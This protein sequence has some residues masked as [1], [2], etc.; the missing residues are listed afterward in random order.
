MASIGFIGVGNMGGPMARNLLKAGHSVKA[1]DLSA[2]LVQKVVDAGGSK[3]ANAAAAAIDVDAVVTMLPAGK[4]VA[5]VYKGDGGILAAAK[6]GTLFIDSSTIDVKTAREVLAAAEARGMPMV[7]APVSGGVAGAENAAL[8]FMVGG[9]DA[10]FAKA[11]PILEAMGKKIVHAGGPGNGQV[12]KICNN[13][14]LGISMIAVSEAFVMAEKLGLSA[15]AMFDIV[16]S[17]SGSCWALLNHCPV[18]GPVPTSAANRDYKP[19][20][21]AELMLKDLKLSQEAARV[22]KVQ[23]PLGAEAA[24]LFAE[25]VEEGNGPTDYSGIIRMIRKMAE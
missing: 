1:F 4:H 14:V 15:Q 19:G 9:S 16:S 10:A 25:Y 18:P 24:A 5:S 6:P 13:M 12:A 7:D 11:K 8:T 22:A 20:F 21:A 23:T 17:S 3:A 2:E